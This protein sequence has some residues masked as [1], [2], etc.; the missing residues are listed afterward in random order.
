MPGIVLLAVHF[1]NP[2]YS[3]MT[4]NKNADKTVLKVRYSR[5]LV[6]LNVKLS[7]NIYQFYTQAYIYTP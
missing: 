1:H 4:Y 5:I 7:I 2:T 6:L 3:A